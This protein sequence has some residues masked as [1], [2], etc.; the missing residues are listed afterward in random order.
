MTLEFKP[1]GHALEREEVA[2]AALNPGDIV[3]SSDGVP[4]VVAGNG[5]IANGERYTLLLGCRGYVPSASAT[6]FTAGATVDFNDTTKLAVASGAGD[7]AIGA[8][9]KAKTSGQ[10][11]VEV[12]MY[13]P[14]AK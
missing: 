11:Q 13:Y 12:Q 5:P 2:S 14:H 9:V 7:F 8:A 1:T 4:G 10:T 3:V 6:T